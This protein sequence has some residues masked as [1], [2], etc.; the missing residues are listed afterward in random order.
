MTLDPDH[1]A[2]PSATE[3]LK[4]IDCLIMKNYEE[5]RKNFLKDFP[6]FREEFVRCEKKFRDAEKKHF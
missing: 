6:D 3:L 2:R 4:R 5:D 1:V